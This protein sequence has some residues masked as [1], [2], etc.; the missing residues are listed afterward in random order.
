MKGRPF[1]KACWDALSRPWTKSTE[2]DL[3]AELEAG[4]LTHFDRVAW[5][6]V[7][8]ASNG[9][10]RSAKWLA[11]RIGEAPIVPEVAQELRIIVI[12]AGIPSLV[13][14]PPETIVAERVDED[15]EK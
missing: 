6:Q 13:R 5:G 11:E 12:G 3:E 2:I 15:D 10:N 14:P 7:L 4:K 1:A 9:D 8:A